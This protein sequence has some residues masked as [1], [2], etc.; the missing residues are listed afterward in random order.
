MAKEL[1]KHQSSGG[2]LLTKQRADNPFRWL[3]RE[4]NRVFENLWLEPYGELE[5][6]PGTFIPAVDVTEN[7]KEVHISAELPG[8]DEKDIN[9][10]VTDSMLAIQGE[11]KQKQE[12]K[13]EGFYCKESSYGT[14]RRVIELPAEVDED[15]AEAKF[16]KGVLKIT[17]PKTEESR[18]KT[19]KIEVKSG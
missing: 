12:Q 3:Q 2:G 13:E 17:L 15:K 16:K 11:K 19:R 6:W 8:M 7:E 9:V 18:A 10:T 4:M 14:F 5:E 1:S